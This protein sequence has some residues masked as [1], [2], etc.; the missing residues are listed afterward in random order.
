MRT[1]PLLPSSAVLSWLTPIHGIAA[2]ERHQYP[3]FGVKGSLRK[4]SH[5]IVDMVPRIMVGSGRIIAYFLRRRRFHFED[6]RERREA[7]RTVS[8]FTLEERDSAEL[9]QALI[10]WPRRPR[11]LNLCHVDVLKSGAAQLLRHDR[12]VDRRP[13]ELD[14]RCLEKVEEGQQGV[15]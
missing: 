10:L 12:P 7:I 5:I 15:V 13:P 14:H 9:L 6:P 8:R 11:L 1:L 2:H 4:Y 3:A